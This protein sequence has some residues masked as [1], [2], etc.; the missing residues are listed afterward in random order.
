MKTIDLRPLKLEQ[1]VKPYSL[2]TEG[3]THN[4]VNG[5][6]DEE[7]K[8][9]QRLR[10][11]VP[12]RNIRCRVQIEELGNHINFCLCGGGGNLGNSGFQDKLETRKP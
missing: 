7:L 9:E 1:K 11:T 8:R 6:S 12:K 3:E 5:G 10:Q 2:Q 4:L